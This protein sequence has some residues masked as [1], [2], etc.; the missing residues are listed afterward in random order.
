M[1][2]KKIVSALLFLA[3][4]DVEINA[5]SHYG[6]YGGYG[7]YGG[8]GEEMELPEDPFE[9]AP[10][11]EFYHDDMD[12][13]EV[14]FPEGLVF[15]HAVFHLHENDMDMTDFIASLPEGYEDY[16]PTGYVMKGEIYQDP[17][18]TFDSVAV[19]LAHEDH[20]EGRIAGYSMEAPEG[21]RAWTFP[22]DLGW[23]KSGELDFSADP[24][25]AESDPII[26]EPAGHGFTWGQEM[27]EDDDG[28]TVWCI[29]NYNDNAADEWASGMY[30]F[31]YAEDSNGVNNGFEQD[32]MIDAIGAGASQ[33][34]AATTTATLL[35]ALM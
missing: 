33:L 28:N 35:L 1:Y 26:G 31:Y 22:M 29:H 17:M 8:Y 11:P 4:A 30:H 34:I 10:A 21:Y 16:T 13:T 25:W 6:S 3:V 7:G 20:S 2:G 19:G 27:M 15:T 32:I 14:E 23:L 9:S 24:A 12:G 5:Y 18:G